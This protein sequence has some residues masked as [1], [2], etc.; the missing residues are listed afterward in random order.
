VIVSDIDGPSSVRLLLVLLATGYLIGK[1]PRGF[2]PGLGQDTEVGGWGKLGLIRWYSTA[3]M[4]FAFAFGAGYFRDPLVVWLCA[5]V[6]FCLLGVLF[7]LR[8]T[9]VK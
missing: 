8:R 3:A 1:D 9:S 2:A 5:G 6:S 4:A 7:W